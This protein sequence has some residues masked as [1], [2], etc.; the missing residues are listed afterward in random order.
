MLAA[1][2]MGMSSTSVVLNSLALTRKIGGAWEG[3][4]TIF[5]K[6]TEE[7]QVPS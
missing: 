3:R 4:K 6:Q 7:R 5:R 2:A 1:L